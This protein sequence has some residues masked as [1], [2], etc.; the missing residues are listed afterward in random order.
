MAEAEPPLGMTFHYDKK[1]SD[2]NPPPDYDLRWPPKV[3]VYDLHYEP[4][5][6][7]RVVAAISTLRTPSG[8]TPL[9]AFDAYKTG[10]AL[11]LCA[12]FNDRKPKIIY[13]RLGE[14][15]GVHRRE[16]NRFFR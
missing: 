9:I 10:D 12:F 13:R 1:F 14:R 5:R 8:I 11:F 15:R 6:N 7:A 4:L 16:R 3:W 2:H